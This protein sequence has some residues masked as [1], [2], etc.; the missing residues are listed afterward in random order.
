LTF[1]LIIFLGAG[2]AVILAGGMTAAM[3]AAAA[4]GCTAGAAGAAGTAAAGAGWAISAGD[5]VMIQGL[6]IQ[7][8]A[9]LQ[10]LVGAGFWWVLVGAGFCDVCEQCAASNPLAGVEAGVAAGPSLQLSIGLPAW[11]GASPQW[12]KASLPQLAQ[13]LISHAST[14]LIPHLLTAPGLVLS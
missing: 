2:Q 1:T 14:T 5:L 6:L 4:G 13:G 3:L 8:W 9:P 12:L 11:L 10:F 7:L